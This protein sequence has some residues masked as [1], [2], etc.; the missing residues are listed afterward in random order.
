MV[1]SVY[2]VV[3]KGQNWHDK[4]SI[5]FDIRTKGEHGR[6]GSGF[7]QNWNRNYISSGFKI[8]NRNRR[9]GLG[10]GFG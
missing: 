10:F 4:R 8:E 6:F 2:L 3:F 9:F 7:G 5:F 1:D